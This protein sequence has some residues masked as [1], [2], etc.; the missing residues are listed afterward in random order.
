MA[1]IYFSILLFVFKFAWSAA[2]FWLKYSFEFFTE[3]QGKP[4]KFE[5]RQKNTKIA[6][7]YESGLWKDYFKLVQAS[8]ALPHLGRLRVKGPIT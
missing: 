2:M 3:R 6:T 8:K 7:I 1:A 5:Y 4:G